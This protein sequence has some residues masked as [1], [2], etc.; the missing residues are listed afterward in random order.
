MKSTI[1]VLSVLEA[2]NNGRLFLEVVRFDSSKLARSSGVGVH[3]LV[4]AHDILPD[5][6]ASSN[7]QVTW[8]SATT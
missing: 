6:T 8:A 2:L 5:N 7:V 3:T 1:A 4:N